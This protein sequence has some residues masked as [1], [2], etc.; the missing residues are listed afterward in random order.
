M[1]SHSIN[2][3]PCDA[4]CRYWAKLVRNGEVLPVPAS[5]QGAN[6]LPASYLQRGDEELLAGDLLFEGEANHHRRTDRGW[7]YWVTTVT[8][9]GALLRFK[10]GFAAQKAQGMVP[11]LLKGAGDV[12][13]MVRIGH[14]LRAGLSVTPDA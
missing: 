11:D 10:G 4:R 2:V 14:G 7:T 8:G 12:A 6:D 1:Q 3:G 9:E 5:V 13:A